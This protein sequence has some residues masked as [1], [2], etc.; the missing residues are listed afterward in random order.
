VLNSESRQSK[1]HARRTL[2]ACGA[3]TYRNDPEIV[4]VSEQKAATLPLV[5]SD[6]E[7]IVPEVKPDSEKKSAGRMTFTPAEPGTYLLRVAAKDASGHDI[8][9]TTT[10]SVVGKKQTA[11]EYRNEVH[12]DLVP[13]KTNYSPGETATVLIKTP[14]AGEALVT[15]GREK[16]MRTFT[17]TLEGNS[18]TIR[19]PIENGD[20]PNVFVSV[21]A[22][23][24]GRWQTTQD[25]AWSLLALTKY[26]EQV[27][28]GTKKIAGSVRYAG[29]VDEFRLDEKTRAFEKLHALVPVVAGKPEPQPLQLLNPS[30]GQLFTVVN[31]EGRPRVGKQPRQDRGYLIQRSY[32]KIKDDGSLAEAKNLRVGDRVLVTLRIEVRQSAHYL[33]VDDPLPAILEAVNPAFKSQAVNVGDEAAGFEG[34]SDF[35]EQ[36]EDRALFFGD[37]VAP[38]NYTIRYVARVRAAGTVTAPAAKIEEMYHPEHFGLTETE[39]VTSVPLE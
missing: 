8:L 6:S 34:F 22:R 24:Q 7:W 9:T 23:K 13:D 31:L 25:N 36:R 5:K 37:H 16:V 21:H 14:I 15:V 4:N 29:A 17:T 1:L 39:S 11:W 3:L 12:I 38:G 32:S 20:A 18:P 30:K 33:A 27:E 10:F 28:T 26:A 35:R 2:G 19:V